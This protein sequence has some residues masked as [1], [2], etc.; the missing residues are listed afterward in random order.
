MG[1]CVSVFMYTIHSIL[2]KILFSELIEEEIKFIQGQSLVCNRADIR[3]QGCLTQ[4]LYTLFCNLL[5]HYC[6]FTAMITQDASS[7]NFYFNYWTLY[8]HWW[9]WDNGRPKNIAERLKSRFVKTELVATKNKLYFK[10]LILY[11]FRWSL[12]H[13]IK[14]FCQILEMHWKYVSVNKI[15][16]C[17]WV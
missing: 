15:K 8:G 3:T 9:L 6:G 1:Y 10:S 14:I 17:L 7:C 13:F 16:W 5:S 11:P 12:I 2:T 4:S